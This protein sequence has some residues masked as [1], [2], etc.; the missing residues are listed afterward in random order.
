[1]RW[2]DRALWHH[3]TATLRRCSPFPA[4]GRRV[5]RCCLVIGCGLGLTLLV[6]VLLIVLLGLAVERAFG[7]APA[8]DAVMLLI[9]NSNSMVDLQG[10]GSD[11]NLLRIEAARLFIA[12]LGVDA[13]E[14]DHRLGVIFFGGHAE[15]VAPLTPLRDDARR[16]E[17]ADRIAQ[18]GRMRWTD[19]NRALEL[20]YGTLFGDPALAAHRPVVILLTDGRPAWNSRPTEEETATYVTR[21]RELVARFRQRGAAIFVILLANEATD[22]DVEIARRYRPLWQEI[23]DAAPPGRFYEIRSADDLV[24]VHRDIVVAL[25]GAQTQGPVVE[26]QVPPAPTPSPT[27]APIPTP[28]PAPGLT[29]IGLPEAVWVGRAVTV[30]ARVR[31]VPGD[32]SVLAD[33]RAPDGSERTIPLL[34][35]GRLADSHAGDGLYAAHFIPQ[36]PGVH[37]VRPEVRRAGDRL[38]TWEGRIEALAEPTLHLVAPGEGAT[39]RVGHLIPVAARWC[40]QGVT[41]SHAWAEVEGPA[42]FSVTLDAE[43]TALHGLLTGLTA[44]GTYTLT[45]GA[46]GQVESGLR[47]AA[48]TATFF[49]LRVPT[50]WWAWALGALALAGMGG[51]CGWLTHRRTRPCVE[52]VLE[53]LDASA[54]EQR[55]D[56]DSLARPV[57]RLGPGASGDVPLDGEVAARIRPGPAAGGAVEMILAVTAGDA[58]V[59]GHP[60]RGD[61]VLRD[62]D[63]L[64]LGG[65]RFRYHNLRQHSAA[66]WRPREHTLRV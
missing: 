37:L 5:R 62:G 63:V 26:A 47:V 38:A 4:L 11:P 40:A 14:A 36:A 51:A 64:T 24:S 32:A 2:P 59:N 31:D 53:R 57:V 7:Q 1:M 33:V 8:G 56:L 27:S 49:R 28:T 18:P 43:G 48:E 55:L 35:D 46:E 60:V 16:A 17:I 19:P 34:D 25:S 29:V 9:D 61:H 66:G 45:V 52:G 6:L 54:G 22:A 44:P 15:L 10:V 39:C 42:A 58:T 65:S 20:A 3:L 13:D 30:T 23:A 41:T 12:T 50:P 21:T